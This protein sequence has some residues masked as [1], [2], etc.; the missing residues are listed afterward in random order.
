VRVALVGCGNIADRYAT[1]IRE[2]EALE[3][4]GATD[5]LAERAAALVAAHGGTAY[6]SLA[7][8]LADDAVDTVVNLTAP[9]AHAAVTRA[10]LEAGKHVHTEKPLALAFGE[11]RELVDLARARGVRLSCAP[12][13]LLGEAQ[14]TAWKLLREGAVGRVRAVYA[15]ANWGRVEGWHPDPET[16]YA[17]GPLVDVGSYPLTTLTAVH[18]PARRVRAFATV[19]E[20]DRTLRDGR[21][22]RLEAAD[23]VVAIVELAAVVVR[24]T[25]SFYVGPSQQRGIEWHGDEGSL[26]LATWAESDSRLELKPR[27]DEY[28]RVPLLREPYA[29]IDWGTAL[30]DLAAAVEEGR[31]HRAAAEHAA[32]VVEVL[33]AI[34]AAAASGATVAVTS[35]FDPPQPLPWAL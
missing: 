3:L 18:G 25:A 28:R 17:V 33:E 23:F 14:Q 16:L 5:L 34:A 9:T 30:L 2:L 29:G 15:E 20:P 4:A 6:P 32:H 27:A 24:L 7:A 11:A 19:L 12:A 13:T 22:L 35:S 26:F 31:P 10:C 21:A 1:R 8:L